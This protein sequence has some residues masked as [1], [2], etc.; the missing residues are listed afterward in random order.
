MRDLWTSAGQQGPLPPTFRSLSGDV[1]VR[2]RRLLACSCQGPGGP[3][4]FAALDLGAGPAPETGLRDRQVRGPGALRQGRGFLVRAAADQRGAERRHGPEQ[5][6]AGRPGRR[7]ACSHQYCRTSPAA[8][9]AGPVVVG[10]D[11]GSVPSR[12]RPERQFEVVA[13]KVIDAGA[14]STASPSPATVR[15]PHPRRS[16]R[17]CRGRGGCGDASDG[18]VRR[19]CRAMAV[20]TRGAAKCHDRAGLVAR[21]CPLRARA[22]GG[23]R[24]RR[25]HG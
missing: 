21:R 15:R 18:A 14:P 5:D 12:P 17:P 13:G 24:P 6:V 23:P 3:K 1:P 2:V 11:G 19:R 7:A 10:L 16:G 8:P 9:A 25:R 4:S 22:A 20:A